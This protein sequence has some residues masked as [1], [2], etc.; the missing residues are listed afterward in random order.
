VS[1]GEVKIFDAFGEHAWGGGVHVKP[2]PSVLKS[3]LI[4]S[5]EREHPREVVTTLGRQKTKLDKQL[6]AVANSEYEP[7]L[8]H[9]LKQT[10]HKPHSLDAA[11][12]DPICTGLGCPK[13]ISVEK[14]PRKNDKLV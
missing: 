8:E 1:N 12:P 13:I 14:A 6:E 5:G 11:V 4:V 7:A 3:P 9:E 2:N 10:V